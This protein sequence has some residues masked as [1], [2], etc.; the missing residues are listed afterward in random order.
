MTVITL[1]LE[2]AAE[3]GVAL[4]SSFFTPEVFDTTMSLANAMRVLCHEQSVA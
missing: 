3:F 1:A 4:P 2:L